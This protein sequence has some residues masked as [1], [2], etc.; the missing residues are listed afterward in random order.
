MH[1][2][3][4]PIFLTIYLYASH[5]AQ[6]KEYSDDHSRYSLFPPGKT[7]I[8]TDITK[9]DCEVDKQGLLKKHIR[10]KFLWRRWCLIWVLCMRRCKTNQNEQNENMQSRNTVGISGLVHVSR[11]IKEPWETIFG[12]CKEFS[13]VKEEEV[14]NNNVENSRFRLGHW[15]PCVKFRKFPSFP[16]PQLPHLSTMEACWD[17]TSHP[18]QFLSSYTISHK[19]WTSWNTLASK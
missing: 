11:Q 9:S 14:V 12:S 7:D 19:Q 3:S 17:D 13:L 18:F 2:Y 6:D 1:P 5:G 16:G 8:Y 10:G 4:H 15:S